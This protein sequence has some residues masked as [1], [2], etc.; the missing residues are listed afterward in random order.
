MLGTFVLSSDYYD[1]YYTKAQEVRQLIRKKTRE[2][3]DN[4]DFIVL[5]TTST[6]AFK[7]G[8][9]TDDPVMMYLSDLFTV[10][11]SI[12]G[13][14]AISIPMGQDKAGMSIG[15]QLMANKFDEHQLLSIAKEFQVS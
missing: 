10:Q 1:D 11:A 9:K 14:P 2:I 5:P 15:I 12:S 4:Y 7:I 3:F 13:I 6:P 8:E